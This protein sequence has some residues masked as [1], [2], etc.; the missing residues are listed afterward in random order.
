MEGTGEG[1]ERGLG[2]GGMPFVQPTR[3]SSRQGLPGTGYQAITQADAVPETSE[4]LPDEQIPDGKHD[5]QK[6]TTA[7]Q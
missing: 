6:V 2:L 3:I 1:H 5:I 4:R 7:S